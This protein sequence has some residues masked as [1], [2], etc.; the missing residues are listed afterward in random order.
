MA[1][2]QKGISSEVVFFLGAGASVHAGVPHTYAF[3][4]EF[5]N[6]PLLD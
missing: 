3:V 1:E 5:K 6:S 4:E 2:E